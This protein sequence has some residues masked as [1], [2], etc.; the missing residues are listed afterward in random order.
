MQLID[1]KKIAKDLENET[2]DKLASFRAAHK[3]IV[4]KLAVVVLGNDSATEVF[5]KKERNGAKTWN[6][7]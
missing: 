4:I 2:K 5:S 1:G 3:G 6:R 7:V